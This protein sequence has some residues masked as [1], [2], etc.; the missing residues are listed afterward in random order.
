MTW[1]WPTVAETCRQ[2]N[3]QDTKTVVFWRTHPLLITKGQTGS[4]RAGSG[5]GAAQCSGL[6]WV[7]WYQSNAP[8]SILRALSGQYFLRKDYLFAAA[9]LLLS[10]KETQR[11]RNA[12]CALRVTQ[13]FTYIKYTMMCQSNTTNLYYVFYCIRA[14]CFDSY[15]I[16]FRPF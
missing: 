9:F 10:W 15:R 2:P 3:K 7:K 4:T 1:E 11:C 6:D 13:R 8:H 5:S 14:T 16:I 12:I